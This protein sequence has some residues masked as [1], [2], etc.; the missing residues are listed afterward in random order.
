MTPIRTPLDV[1]DIVKRYLA[2]E[3][4]N[5]LAEAFSVDRATIR[6]RL[7]ERGIE[8]RGKRPNRHGTPADI[9][10]ARYDAGESVFSISNALGI[11]RGSVRRRLLAGGVALRTGSEANVLRMQR[12]TAEERQ[13]L[14][15]SANEAVRNREHTMEH[16]IRKAQGKQLHR[17][18]TVGTGENE[19]AQMIQDRTLRPIGRQ[20]PVSKYNV[21]IALGR[22]AVEVHYGPHHPLSVPFIPRRIK[23][24]ID[25]GWA[26]VY[27]WLT[28]G[29][30]LTEAAADQAIVLCD[31]ANGYPSPT[32]Q[33]WVIRG[34]GEI[35]SAGSLDGDEFPVKEASKRAA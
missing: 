23:D 5:R 7:R 24:L 25:L 3:S 6:H 29:N 13:A 32:R 19:F 18:Q 22:V 35:V 4:V 11:D 27:V 16:R 1:D 26:V 30:F 8:L 14:A 31:L 12:M 9:V 10:I 34:S 15:S 2:G 28:K 17:S 21:D 33:Y 20:V